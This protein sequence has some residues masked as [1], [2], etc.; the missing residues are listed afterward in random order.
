[1]NNK[2][3]KYYFNKEATA[4]A[5]AFLEDYIKRIGRYPDPEVLTIRRPITIAYEDCEVRFT[6]PNFREYDINV[7]FKVMGKEYR[8]GYILIRTEDAFAHVFPDAEDL[9]VAILA[10]YLEI[11]VNS[12]SAAA[13]AAVFNERSE[14][15]QKYAL[16][17]KQRAEEAAAEVAFQKAADFAKKEKNGIETIAETLTNIKIV[18]CEEWVCKSGKKALDYCLKVFKSAKGVKYGLEFIFETRDNGETWVIDSAFSWYE[19]RFG[20]SWDPLDIQEELSKE[21]FERDDLLRLKDI[22][23][24]NLEVNLG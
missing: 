4:R 20:S 18:K 2:Y 10:T 6:A 22:S 16:A 12:W 8:E 23:P 21:Y 5:V 9:E 24:V 14:H 17:E 3:N 13:E 15:A 11:A 19:D 1:M 7:R